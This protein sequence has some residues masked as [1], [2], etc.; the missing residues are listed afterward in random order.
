MFRRMGL[1]LSNVPIEKNGTIIVQID[2]LSYDR[3]RTALKRGRCPFLH[4]LLRQRKFKLYKYLSE[5]PTSTPAFQGGMFYGENDN[6]PGFCFYDKAE[7]R[8]YRMG[9]AECAFSV[10][11]SFGKQGLLK[12]GSV[13]SCVYTGDADSVM[14]TFSTTL[15]PRRWKFVFR[16][17]D[18]LLLT[19]VN[20]ATIIKTLLLAGFEL[21]LAAYDSVKWIVRE[22]WVGRELGL[23][24]M[25]VSLTIL[26]RELITLGA[27]LDIYRRV[28]LIY[29]NYLSY[30]E[31]SHFRGP[32]SPVA[33]WTLRGVDRAI[34]RIYK[35]TR[36]S[37]RKYHLYILSD[38]GQCACRPFD[39]LENETIGEYVQRQLT[40]ATVE[41][42][43]QRD[44]RSA[45]LRRTVES[46]RELA[47]WMPR[48]FRGMIRR[49]A[50]YVWRK[51]SPDAGPE[52]DS[53]LDVTVVS[54]GPV[55][56]IYWNREE[57]A[58]TA[59]KIERLHPGLLDK[60]ARHDSIG[61]ISVRTEDGDVLI[62]G[63]NGQAIIRSNGSSV[64]GT[65]PFDDSTDP[66][67]VME[68]IRR[69]TMFQRSGDIC[70]WGGNS[71]KGNVSYSFEFGA[72]SGWT[73][74]EI[75]AFVMS[76]SYINKDFSQIRSHRDF[77]GFFKRYA[78][79]A[80]SDERN[81][82]REAR[83]KDEV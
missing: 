27:V 46:L 26:T 80:K 8:L 78:V 41:N 50:N 33:A 13:F 37:D 67:Y 82:K 16:A 48:I 36:L 34:R 75:E 58:L 24:G 44:E 3:F 40:D 5:I 1:P 66:H 9:N 30:D 60:L 38:H 77:Y 45:Q 56:F 74:D 25:R 17:F 20:L 61:C 47:A 76:P 59:E 69:L 64:S 68:G 57:Q 73:D 72:H 10:E 63:R 81:E 4:K 12:G 19:L 6:I 18:I 11:K 28:P 83:M 15:A 62:R 42:F 7:K 55:A 71:P 35:A 54:S 39:L 51:A 29:V 21:I 14:L 79:E 43:I 32:D 49:Y 52:I 65:L 31:E 2:G 23:V 70:L 53:L 22:G